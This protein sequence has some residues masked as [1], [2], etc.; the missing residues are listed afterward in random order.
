MAT[1]GYLR[2]SC[3]GKQ[4]LQNQRYELLDY[5]QKNHL[6]IDEFIEVEISSR[7]DADKRRI[8]ELFG[9]LK[10]GDT[11]VVAELSRLG[12]STVECIDMVN[13]L[14]EMKVTFIALKQNIH[15][16]GK[17]D[18][19]TK[20]MITMFSLF[21]ELEKDLI[22]AR[23]IQ[24]LAAKKAQGIKLGRPKGSLG[25]SKLDDKKEQIE[26]FLK[27]G[28]AKAAISRM[29]KVSRGALN[30]YIRSRKVVAAA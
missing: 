28:V 2:V 12:R 9:K 11:L 22:S 14:I 6:E 8:T 17:N 18:I 4:D 20:V 15:I 5:A 29:L 25:A 16:N 1:Y 30:D 3:K 24:A 23:T 21:A 19:A 27:H 26:E 10:S 13:R 7:K